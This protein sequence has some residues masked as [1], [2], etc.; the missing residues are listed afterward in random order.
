MK[1]LLK[2]GGFEWGLEAE[3]SFTRLKEAVVKPPVLALPKFSQPFQIECDAL[4]KVIRAV[5]MQRGHPIAFYSQAL[6]GRALSP[7]T[8]EKELLALVTAVQKWTPY[9]LGSLFSIKTDHQS[10]K[11]LLDQKIGTPMPKKWVSKLLGYDFIVEYESGRE[12]LVAD[13]LSK[14]L[15]DTEV[16]LLAVTLIPVPKIA[17]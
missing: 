15:E 14:Q 13:G 16:S 11:F 12:T 3:E 8:Y 2:K 9:L 1:G 10:L 5:L 17:L 6:K 7:S 4:G